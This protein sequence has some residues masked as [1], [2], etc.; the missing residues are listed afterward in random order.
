MNAYNNDTRQ[1]LIQAHNLVKTY[2]M[3]ST[4][5]RALDGVSLEINA[6]EF[7]AITG[8]SGSGKST[9]MHILGC[10]D[11]PTEGSYLIGKTDVSAASKD[12]LAG[13]RNQTIG[14]VFQKFY[15][16]P[17]LTAQEN[18]ALPTLYGRTDEK[19]A[20]DQAAELL[21]LVKLDQRID[22]Y[23]YQLS[24][25]QQQRV[26]IARA[27]ANKPSIIMADEPTGNLDTATGEVIM[28]LLKE[29]NESQKT[30]IIL[31]THEPEIA[32]KAHR[33]LDLRDGKIKSDMR[34]SV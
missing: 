29:L 18:V 3:G 31:V 8:T 12:E 10:L 9:L 26:A 1:A 6:G 4:T 20:M 11:T 32:A 23:P 27:F 25:G 5:V 16:L 22:H 14:F 19:I 24:G 33:I 30:T 15:L 13:I 34:R 21:K 2:T 7:V 28:Q 17:D